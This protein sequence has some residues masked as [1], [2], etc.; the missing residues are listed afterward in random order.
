MNA[1]GK[2]ENG[3]PSLPLSAII[4][5]D[6]DAAIIPLRSIAW[7]ASLRMLR[8]VASTNLRTVICASQALRPDR[9]AAPARQYL[10]A[11]CRPYGGRQCGILITAGPTLPIMSTH[12]VPRQADCCIMI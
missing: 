12:H 8:F 4:V 6:L 10:G 1:A 3:P 7:Q 11:L 2:N 9:G 5:L